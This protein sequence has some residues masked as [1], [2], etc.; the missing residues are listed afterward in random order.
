MVLITGPKLV[1]HYQPIAQRFIQ[2]VYDRMFN[3][4]VRQSED[5]HSNLVIRG[6]GDYSILVSV[7]SKQMV[8]NLCT[9]QIPHAETPHFCTDCLEFL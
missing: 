2:Y 1:S 5:K 9:S 3:A 4:S 6:N 7:Y 8:K